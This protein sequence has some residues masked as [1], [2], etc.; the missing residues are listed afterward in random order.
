MRRHVLRRR[1]PPR[2]LVI[3]VLALVTVL[4]IVFASAAVSA[5]GVRQQLEDGRDA[6]EQGREALLDGR[7]AAAVEAFATA[8]REFESAGEDA[9]SRW[10]ALAGLV[11]IAG[12]TADAIGSLAAAGEQTADAAAGFAAAVEF[13]PGGL[14]S[15]A[16]SAQGIPLGPLPALAEAM[17]RAETLTGRA[18]RGL[19]ASPGSLVLAPVAEARR[20]AV[21]ELSS[22]NEQLHAGALI[23]RE[24]PEFLGATE[25][26]RY[27]FGAANPA[28][29]R[30]TGGLIGAYSILT[31]E[32]GRMRFEDF[33][34]VESLPRLPVEEAPSPSA[35]YSRNFD[36]YRTGDGFWLNINMTPD[37][38]LAAEA[39]WLTYQATVGEELDGVIVADP[40]A[41]RALMRVTGPVDVPGVDAEVSQETV[42]P[43][44]TNE[45]YALFDTQAE[46]KLVLG[47]VSKS[48][49]QGF[50]E[51]RG[52]TK[53]RLRALS[54]AFEDGHVQ[55]W[56]A[57]EA[58]QDGLRLTTVG[59]AFA[60]SG[61]DL[62]SVV[63]NSASGTKLDF[64]QERTVSYEVFLGPVGS[65]SATLEVGLTNDSPTAG[66]PK[67]VIG[68]FPGFGREAGENI[69]VVHLYCDVGCVLRDAIRAG[70]RVRLGRFEQEGYPLFEDY[71]RS[72]PGET[73]TITTELFLPEA[74]EGDEEAGGTYH[75][76]LRNQ[77]TIRPTQVRVV[78]GLPD[79]MQLTSSTP[80]LRS[81]EGLVVY[82]GSPSGD[83]ELEVS[84]APP[85]PI[86]VWRQLTDFL[87]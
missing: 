43:F 66:L 82:E 24:L 71:V 10:L 2:W 58:M 57:D 48:V 28:E 59:G 80:G 20:E 69:A 23:L 84:F 30:G 78:I 52:G 33:V 45:A 77:Q 12:R 13:L 72:A 3:S 7:T 83:L 42:V 67:Y 32:Q 9:R 11:P 14:T 62:V 68:P 70:E 39:I 4:L 17:E 27:F 73:A 60:G 26:R 75:L 35:A 44:T 40:F 18:L 41:L 64:Y 15:L 87:G 79:G 50:L 31:F 61:T 5:L 65:A 8:Q 1:R 16:P 54:R 51:E 81:E 47:N 56:S 25:P 85:L 36:F 6:L 37:F 38:P 55:I 21:D 63:T 76:T 74:W 34:P 46:R 22:L 29:L 86:R 53:D 19:A 49:V